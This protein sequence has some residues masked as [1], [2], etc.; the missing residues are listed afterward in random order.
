M[1]TTLFNEEQIMKAHDATIA[2]ESEAKGIAKGENRVVNLINKL[3]DI[4]RDKEISKVTT[5]VI[6]RNKLMAE[7]G[8]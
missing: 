5:D 4:G 2:R 3:I 1:Y 8:I 7:F 6:Y